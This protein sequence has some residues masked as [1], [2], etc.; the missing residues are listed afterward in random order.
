MEE[1]MVWQDRYNIGVEVIDREH[2]RLFR[3]INRLLAYEQ[4]KGPWACQ[5]GIKYFKAHAVKHFDEE[6]AY[7]ASIGYPGLETH[8]K[9]HQGFR[10]GTL[11][12][13]ERELIETNYSPDAVEHF[14]GVCSGWLIGHTLT[15]DQAIV[16]S[17]TSKWENLLSKDKMT[18]LTKII[19]QLLF[20]MFQLESELVSDTYA[21]ERFGHGVYYRLVYEE[22]HNSQEVILALE[23][24][25][26]VNTVGRILGLQ[27]SKLDQ[28]LVNAVRYTARQFV[29]QVL[30]FFPDA[31]RKFKA[32]SLL[33]YEQLQRVFQTKK[34]QVSLLF[35]TGEGYLAYCSIAP[36]QEESVTVTPIQTDNA[37]EEVERYL[38]DREKDANKPSI[39][40]V[41]DSVTVRQAMRVLLEEDYNVTLVDSGVAAIRAI[42]LD[43]PD[44][45]LLDY[46]MPVCNGKQTLEMLRSEKSF[47]GIP[48]IFLT[49]HSE[50]E[51]VRALLAL[52]PA[53][54]LLK[55]LKPAEI[56]EKIDELFSRLCR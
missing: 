12:A 4:D 26:M 51:S 33:S 49:S 3:I 1:Q 45:V 11:P 32:E 10:N 47:N 48:V 43:R 54:Y 14:L 56:K 52:K 22:G 27:T 28:M 44:M 15:E 17:G 29:D 8:R 39:L 46:E 23:E 16:G 9:I 42:S 25:L 31:P 38:A 35:N 36:A 37:I 24:K 30:S 53:G 40:V 34:P 13:L 18:A 5:E 21:G 19:T 55:Y 7:M 41:D 50:P 20:N 6:E 2:Q